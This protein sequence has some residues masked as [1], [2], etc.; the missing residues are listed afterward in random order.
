MV[1]VSGIPGLM[2]IAADAEA[3]AALPSVIVTDTVLVP[4]T[5]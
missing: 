2:I 1:T 5:E 3:V 4:L